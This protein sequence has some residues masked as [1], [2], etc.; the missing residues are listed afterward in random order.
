MTKDAALGRFIQLTPF[1]SI[2]AWL[3]QN[4]AEARRICE[5][6]CGRHIELFNAWE[7]DRGLLDQVFKPKSKETSCL[8]DKHNRAL[9][10]KSFPAEAAFNADKS[11]AAAVMDLLDRP[12]LR[13]AVA[14]TYA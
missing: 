3:Y 4:I 9:A 8:E 5:A 10:E 7:A 1:Y 13:A 2:E 11:Y 14:C 12:D 6:S